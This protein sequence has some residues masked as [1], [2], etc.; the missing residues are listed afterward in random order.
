MSKLIT[1]GCSLTEGRGVDN[2]SV[3]SWPAVL[4]NHLNLDLDNKGK[5]GSSNKQIW[6]NVLNYNQYEKNDLVIILW[7][8]N[9]RYTIIKNIKDPFCK[10]NFTFNPVWVKGKKYVDK[11][12]AYYKHIYDEQD[13]QLELCSKMNHIDL[14][15][16]HKLNCKNVVHLIQNEFTKLDV[17]WS[18]IKIPN[19]YMAQ[20][21]KKYPLGNDKVHP[22]KE[23]YYNFAKDL[24][25]WIKNEN[26][27]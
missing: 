6:L 18:D 21:G 23:A 25:D 19:I 17:I 8:H 20:Y 3:E 12:D 13:M 16:K 1:F 14:Y 26:I 27:F 4:S 7:S 10:K 24:F 15:L 2:K 22:G 9:T 11:W 5:S